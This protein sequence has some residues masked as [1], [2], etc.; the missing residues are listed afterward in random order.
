MKI[1]N[2]EFKAKV[3]EL[4]KYE[5]KLLTLNPKFIGIDHQVDTYFNTLKARLKLREGNIENALIQ[6]DREDKADA[7]ESSVILY[8]HQPNIALK[9]I[10]IN[11]FGIKAIVDK[12]R[13]IYFIKNVKFHFDVV[14]N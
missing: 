9:N 10:L 5:Q 7:K 4:E 14:I 11:Q 1:I 6:Y 8:I 3:N 12:K 13:K 2:V